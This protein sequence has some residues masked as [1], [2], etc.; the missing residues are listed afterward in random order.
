M[1]IIVPVDVRLRVQLNVA[2]D[3]HADDGVYEKQHAD[4]QTDVGQCLRGK[5]E[6]N[7]LQHRRGTVDPHL[8]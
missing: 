8:L 7:E 5:N 1:E 6:I 4:Q 3:L 2:E